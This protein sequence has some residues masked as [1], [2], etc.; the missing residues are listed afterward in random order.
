MDVRL[1][2]GSELAAEVVV[3]FPVGKVFVL[4]F[5]VALGRGGMIL[6]IGL[7]PVVVCQ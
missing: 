2:G 4:V 5:A 3:D 1:G 6:M 7:S